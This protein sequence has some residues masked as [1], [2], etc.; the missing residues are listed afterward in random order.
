MLRW[1]RISYCE[2]IIMQ[3][4]TEHKLNSQ[5][6]FDLCFPRNESRIND[7]RVA[8]SLVSN[9]VDANTSI[10]SAND[11]KMIICEFGPNEMLITLKLT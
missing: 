8:F 2:L 7:Q 6:T 3:I 5:Q 10:F 4:P 1:P 11:L 9:N